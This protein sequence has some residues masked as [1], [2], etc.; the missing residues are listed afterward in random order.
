MANGPAYGRLIGRDRELSLLARAVSGAADGALRAVAVRGDPGMGKTRLLAELAEMARA[1]G[2]AVHHGQATEFE[3]HVPFGVYIAAFE[4]QPGD[5]SRDAQGAL[6]ELLL[7]AT[8]PSEA[9]RAGLGRYRL[10][11]RA[12]RLI[13]DQG[14][15]GPV[16]IVLD[17]LHWADQSSVEL[18][19]YLLRR[20]PRAPLLLATAY[21]AAQ[22]PAG[23]ARA[24]AELGEAAVHIG[25][26]PLSETDVAALL[27]EADR[28]R[29]R[30]LYRTTHGNPLYLQVLA[31]AGVETLT[32]F[33][34][35]GG[36]ATGAP[37]RALLDVLSTELTALTPEVRQVACAAAVAGEPISLDL[38]ASIT[39]LPEAALDRA[40][41]HLVGVGL[42]V[43]ADAA[44]RFRHPLIRAAAYWMSGAAWRSRAH[45]RAA[46]H[47]RGNG[48]P[49]QLLA[50]HTARSAQHGDVQAVRTL[51]AAASAALDA[52]PSTAVRLLRTAI[53]LLPDEADLALWR[54]QLQWALGRALG[55][56]GDLAASRQILQEVMR[57]PGPLRIAAVSFSS[58]IY[59]LLGDYDEAKALVT[60]ELTRPHARDRSTSLAQVGLAA[61]ELMG[62]EPGKARLAA[63]DAI[64]S[65]SDAD[66]EALESAART[67]HAL[68]SLRDGHVAQSRRETDRAA[69]LTDAMTDDVL[70]PHLELIAPLAWV[71][72]HL[73]RY[74]DASRHLRRGL[75]IA[76]RAG[77]S[78]SVPYL[79][80]ALS[81]LNERQGRL[82][83]AMT[84]AE[85]ARESSR[86][87]HSG[88]T[89]AMSSIL[90]LRP[91]LW[92]DG[93][94][95][96]LELAERISGTR[97]R[98]GWWS[99]LAQLDLALVYAEAGRPDRALA[100]LTWE[101][102]GDEPT[103]TSCLALQAMVTAIAGAPSEAG[104]LAE[105]ALSR[106]RKS[107]LAHQ[108]GSAHRAQAKVLMLSGRPKEAVVH[109]ARG[110]DHFAAAGAPVEEGL[111]RQLAA[112]LYAALGSVG[113][114]RD[115]IGRA[116]S[117]YAAT[118]AAW[119]SA[120][121]TRDER[122][123]A[124]R[125]PRRQRQ[126]AGPLSA[127]TTRERQIADLA[128]D[129]LTN[130][131]I[132]ERLYLSPK[133]V[134]AH[135]SRTFAKLGVQSRVTL[136][137]HLA[138][139]ARAA[140]DRAAAGPDGGSM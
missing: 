55:V 108:L 117:L 49:L 22:V 26:A 21:R 124:A 9:R 25:L 41:D 87:I 81:A 122:R 140:D 46:E 23:I 56:T 91:L 125:A 131:Q 73:R 3:R 57:A 15:A 115:E 32:A 42:V 47:L 105:D 74:D 95:A 5:P 136:S 72:I 2:F 8:G 51:E 24:V 96:A 59:R 137:Q 28:G 112:E 76:H 138:A 66:D 53:R 102:P 18:T 123:L 90:L 79:L 13:E 29:R 38:L 65:L 80:I 93:P 94:R 86:L 75:D 62:R 67:I 33:G 127:L 27:P 120:A 7:D 130:Q 126:P 39:E 98:S 50:H 114:V 88:E 106:A 63:A 113:K 82:S 31:D 133:T 116:K 78:H 54:V 134:E 103:T 35:A 139:D 17:D 70:A 111:T 61:V 10:F 100:V 109:A 104:S 19:E 58:M 107:G 36:A 68:A 135:L 83:E 119:L 34:E 121:L 11:Q 77:R 1:R 128:A 97:P 4:P 71:E 30:L 118:G 52:A 101:D 44:F 132:A 99:G 60:T 45:D 6:T 64:R 12:R 85:E 129:G 43:E 84:A 16:A 89:L 14:A 48:G 40:I 69:W 20:P 37:E 110:A 92:R